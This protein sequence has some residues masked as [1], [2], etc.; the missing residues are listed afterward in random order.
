MWN[1]VDWN[2]FSC[3]VCLLELTMHFLPPVTTSIYTKIKSVIIEKYTNEFNA[4]IFRKVKIFTLK[5]QLENLQMKQKIKLKHSCTYERGERDL[6]TI[7]QICL[8]EAYS[9]K[10]VKF[11]QQIFFK[12]SVISLKKHSVLV[13][14]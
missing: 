13:N 11:L 6:Q 5:L 7:Y 12:S 1:E 8:T 2:Q 3:K 10:L 4:I 9:G 14:I